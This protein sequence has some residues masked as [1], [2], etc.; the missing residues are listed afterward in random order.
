MP[1]DAMHAVIVG[2]GP[3]GLCLAGLLSGSGWRVSVFE[4]LSASEIT[5]ISKDY[6]GRAYGVSADGR[7][8]RT[9]EA[10]GAMQDVLDS[11]GYYRQGR[12]L[13]NASGVAV[14]KTMA[15]PV[16]SV[17]RTEMC[18]ALLRTLERD[19]KSSVS[20]HFCRRCKRGTLRTDGQSIVTFEDSNGRE[21]DIAGNVIVFSDGAGFSSMGREIFAQ[22]DPTFQWNREA[23]SRLNKSILLKKQPSME[24]NHL[25][26]WFGRGQVLLVGRDMGKSSPYQGN[27]LAQLSFPSEH[28]LAANDGVCSE[29]EFRKLVE[30]AL[31]LQGKSFPLEVLVSDEEFG[32]AATSKPWPNPTHIT[33]SKFAYG[34]AVLVGD[35][36]HGLSP[37]LGQGMNCA[38]ESVRIL[39]ATLV[40]HPDDICLALKKFENKR[41]PDIEALHR[42]SKQ[43]GSS[44]VTWRSKIRDRLYGVTAWK[45]LTPV[46]PQLQDPNVPYRAIEVNLMLSN[47]LPEIFGCLITC[48]FLALGYSL[49]RQTRWG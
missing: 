47:R 43:S 17:M 37:A 19:H 28:A 6:L 40:E 35:A 25:H 18:A 26:M 41:K 5:S 46:M 4:K 7:S 31:Q 11:G 12:S 33:C 2:A 10:A 16:F 13:Y 9:V 49:R 44:T 38:L 45:V 48:S 24:D 1:K 29:P 39:H 21:E 22:N 3:A 27:L 15:A 34:N 8:M 14:T 20:V 36:A 42:I 23:V 32:R 30:D